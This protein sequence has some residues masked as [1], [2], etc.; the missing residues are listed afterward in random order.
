METQTETQHV[1]TINPHKLIDHP[2]NRHVYGD[3][4]VDPGLVDSIR[5]HGVQEPIVVVETTHGG[6][7][8]LFILSGHRRVKAAKAVGCDVPVRILEDEGDDWQKSYL[9]EANRQRIKN[10]EQ[11]AREYIE[12]KRLEKLN[13]TGKGTASE[14]SAEQ[15]GLREDKARRLEVIIEAADKG[16]PIA[17]EGLK[18]INTHERS[19]VSVFNSVT[20]GEEPDTS[21]YDG[22]AQ[23]LAEDTNDFFKVTHSP[24]GEWEHGYVFKIRLSNRADAEAFIAMFRRIPAEAQ[25]DFI[26]VQS[27]NQQ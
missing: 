26:A 27:Q 17:I 18:K 23:A 5:E 25:E 12:L 6:V 14:R 21:Y 10:T 20:R 7:T 4:A 15:V 24:K 11:L 2:F 13:P 16:D 22:V 1:S 8:G 9:L 3:E 19:V